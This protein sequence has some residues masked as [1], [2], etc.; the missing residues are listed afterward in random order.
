MNT[1]APDEFTFRRFLTSNDPIDGYQQMQMEGTRGR[2]LPFHLFTRALKRD[3]SAGSFSKG[4]AL[5]GEK[6]ESEIIPFMRSKS[7]CA[8]LG[9]TIITGLVPNTGTPVLTSD[10][11]A[12]WMQESQAVTPTD[13]SLAQVLTTPKRISAS[14][15]LSKLL[16]IQSPE[17]EHTVTTEMGAKIMQAFDQA[18]L[19]GAGGSAPIGI[20]N[21]AGVSTVSF[22]GAASLAKLLNFEQDVF[23]ANTDAP[24]MGWAQS[25]ATR[26]RWKQIQKAAG[27]STFLQDDSGD[28]IGY[29]SAVTTE[30]SPA[31]GGGDQCIF[32]NWS[33]LIL[34]IFF[35]GFWVSNNPYSLDT[36][37]EN[38][39]TIHLYADCSIRLPASFVLSNDSAAQ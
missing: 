31:N 20:L 3:M 22:G 19:T 29:S 16:S 15:I 10:F 34:G 4:G 27:T 7:V 39:I 13:V 36:T 25:P 32:G 2:Y 1:I 8:R 37:F 12:Q 35:Q 26:S 21:A 17:F 33:D 6:V 11:N 18:A 23:T 14:I 5:V 9:A 28:V 30:L 38:R 24:T